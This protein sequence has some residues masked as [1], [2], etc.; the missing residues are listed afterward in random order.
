MYSRIVEMEW[1]YRPFGEKWLIEIFIPP[2][3]I[4]EIL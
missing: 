4:V 1:S 2:N 3:A